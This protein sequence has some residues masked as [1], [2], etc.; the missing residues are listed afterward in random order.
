MVFDIRIVQHNCYI[1]NADGAEIC[2]WASNLVSKLLDIVYENVSAEEVNQ[3]RNVCS[4]SFSDMTDMKQFSFIKSELDGSIDQFPK[5]PKPSAS[6]RVVAG[7]DDAAA[8]A[9]Q[10]PILDG[11]TPAIRRLDPEVRSKMLQLANAVTEADVDG[12]FAS[13]VTEDIAPGYF[14]IVSRPMDLSTVR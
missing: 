9:D 14:S 13:P 5:G 4:Y 7:T 12:I 6:R 8:L 2:N 1:Y 11:Y 10:Q 3:L